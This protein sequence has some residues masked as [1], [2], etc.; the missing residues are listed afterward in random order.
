MLVLR[1][2]WAVIGSAFVLA[3][4]ASTVKTIV[5]PRALPTRLTRLHFLLVRR[6][7]D[8]LSGAAGRSRAATG[9]WRCTRRSRSWRCR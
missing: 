9:S 3:T 4:L 2:I 6:V 1:V 8:L 7:F 5:V